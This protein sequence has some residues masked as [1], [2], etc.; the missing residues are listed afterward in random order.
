MKKIVYVAVCICLLCCFMLLGC[1]PTSDKECVFLNEEANLHDEYLVTVLDYGEIREI[2]ILK[3]KDDGVPSKIIGTTTHFLFV[4]LKIQ[5]Q[6]KTTPKENHKLDK[7]DFKIKDHTGVQIKNVTFLQSLDACA[8][9]EVEFS[10]QSALVDYTWVDK[11]IESGT[12][13]EVCVYFE[14][15]R[16]FDIQNTLMV[17]EIDFFATKT[18]TDIVLMNRVLN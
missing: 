4:N 12:T 11:Q 16:D 3:D 18:G 8:K 13:I 17:L 5:H 10:T 14:F 9:S 2:N 6:T 15:N 7:N 1:T